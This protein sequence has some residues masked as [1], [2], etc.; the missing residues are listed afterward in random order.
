[1]GLY[2]VHAFIGDSCIIT[3]STQQEGICT[4]KPKCDIPCANKTPIL[5]KCKEPEDGGRLVLCCPKLKSTHHISAKSNYDIM[6]TVTV[7]VHTSI[8]LINSTFFRKQNVR[9]T[10]FACNSSYAGTTN[11]GAALPLKISNCAWETQ[12]VIVK[13][14]AA[15]RREFPHMVY[16]K[17]VSTIRS[18]FLSLIDLGFGRL[19]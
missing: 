4:E 2:N 17:M 18:C 5:Q 11:D 1:M 9:S 6:T 8:V 10:E 13:G 3:A 7:T 14:K 15:N 16:V 12:A 19:G